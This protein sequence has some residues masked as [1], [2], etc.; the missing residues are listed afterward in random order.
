MHD[1]DPHGR[2]PDHDACGAPH[3][4]RRAGASVRRGSCG[5]GSPREGDTH[6]TALLSSTMPTR[7]RPEL[8]ERALRSVA[9]AVGPVAEHIEVAVPMGR[10]T[11]PPAR[12]CS[13]S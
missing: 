7:N 6:A 11:T 3:T 1:S 12:L 8:L 13:G 2:Q 9:R 4:Y 5:H 10:T